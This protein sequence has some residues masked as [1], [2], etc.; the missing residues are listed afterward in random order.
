MSDRF[1]WMRYPLQ[2][3][4]CLGLMP[5]VTYFSKVELLVMLSKA[6]FSVIYEMSDLEGTD[7]EFLLLRKSA[8]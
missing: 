4:G 5:R 6:G 8:I 2:L 3:A 7:A 1:A